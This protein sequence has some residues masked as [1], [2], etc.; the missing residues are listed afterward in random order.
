MNPWVLLILGGAALAV[1]GRRRGSGSA[2]PGV[3]NLGDLGDLGEVSEG[4]WEGSRL[5]EPT[6]YPQVYRKFGDGMVTLQPGEAVALSAWVRFRPSATVCHAWRLEARFVGGDIA[7]TEEG[8]L[9][10]PVAAGEPFYCDTPLQWPPDHEPRFRVEG[11]T[12]FMEARFPPLY[13]QGG[14]QDDPAFVVEYD[15]EAA[16]AVVAD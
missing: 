9:S 13:A 12:V 5:S 10:E 6:L 8:A 7:A 11:N 16:W 14:N 3:A 2:T 15:I 4:D 1:A